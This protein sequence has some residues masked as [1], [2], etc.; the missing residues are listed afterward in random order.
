MLLPPPPPPPPTHTHKSGV[1]SPVNQATYSLEDENSITTM[2]LL[3]CYSHTY[4]YRHKAYQLS[5]QCTLMAFTWHDGRYARAQM[6]RGGPDS[7]AFG[8]GGAESMAL[9][10]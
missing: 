5:R 6:N 1:P 8:M 4:S 3:T 7:C 9:K 2:R 10:N